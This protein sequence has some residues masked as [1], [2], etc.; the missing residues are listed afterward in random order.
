MPNNTWN[1]KFKIGDKVFAVMI[2]Y[3]IITRL[4]LVKIIGFYS[5][6][7]SSGYKVEVLWDFHNR[8]FIRFRKYF[9]KWIEE[10]PLKF[11]KEIMEHLA[12]G[13]RSTGD[14]KILERQIQTINRELKERIIFT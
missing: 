8:R 1:P 7:Y 3:N 6:G 4:T 13:N 9:Y 11:K 14:F 10:M 12:I 2:F 5:W